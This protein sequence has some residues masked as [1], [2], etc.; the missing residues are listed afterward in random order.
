MKFILQAALAVAILGGAGVTRADQTLLN[1][2]YD[3]TRE[4]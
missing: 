3:V 1:V 2:S 4:P